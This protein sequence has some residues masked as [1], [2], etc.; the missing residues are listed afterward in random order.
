MGG[1]LYGAMVSNGSDDCMC[2]CRFF[3]FLGSWMMG[4][5]YDFSIPAMVAVSV[6]AQLLSIPLY[7]ASSRQK[8]REEQ[9]LHE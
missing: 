9:P 8:I 6:A 4:A 5:L 1:Y 7:L 3:W 2:S